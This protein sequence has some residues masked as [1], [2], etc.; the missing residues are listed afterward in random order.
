M[1][2]LCRKAVGNDM[3]LMADV[4]YAWPDWKSALKASRDDQR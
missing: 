4:A 3:V 2:K 1:V